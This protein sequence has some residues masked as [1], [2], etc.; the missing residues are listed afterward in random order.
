MV[1]GI[2]VQDIE[3]ALLPYRQD[4]EGGQAYV[5]TDETA[6]S[7]CLPLLK[8]LQAVPRMVLPGG[9]AA[10]TIDSVQRIWDFLMAHNAT[11]QA[12]LFNVGGG[13]VTDMGGFA[14]A[15]Y[16]RGI[17]FVNL[18]TTLLSMVDASTG[19]KT[20]VNFG[21]VK[22]AVGTFAQPAA[23]LVY[24]PFLKTLPACEW[25]SGYAEMLKH[26]LIDG[27]ESWQQLSAYDIE[28]RDTERIVP[29]LAYSLS[30]K[31][32]IVHDDPTEQGLRKVLNFGHTVGHAIEEM[33]AQQQKPVPHGY[34]VLWGMVAE[35]YLSVTQLGCP[36]EPL[37]QLTHCMVAYYGRPECNCRQ[38]N[39]LLQ[40][41]RQ[42]KKNRNA[43]R[44]NFTLL[45]G[46]GSPVIDYTPDETAINEALDYL[47]SL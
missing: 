32:R 16:K 41:M 25:L 14:A 7:C 38:Q 4:I 3:E 45:R 13:V 46:I 8:G 31:E 15:T 10:K 37:R 42:D 6:G 44:I 27:T 11:R 39:T 43:D 24:T 28:R 19:G 22:N 9:E 33:Y 40:W 35:L 12:V 20:G 17:R 29:L 2:L 36:R 34:C 23:A 21:G 26:A 1:E 5:L 30:V 18:P 47:F